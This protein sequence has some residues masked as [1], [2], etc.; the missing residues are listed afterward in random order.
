M[1]PL[2][3]VLSSSKGA[4]YKQLV[5]LAIKDLKN[6]P[7]ELFRDLGSIKTLKSYPEC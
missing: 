5:T 7:E 1:I 6:D 4:K 2:P 3:Q